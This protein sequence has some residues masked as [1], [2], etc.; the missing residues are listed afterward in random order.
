MEGKQNLIFFLLVTLFI[1]HGIVSGQFSTLW[2]T[3]FTRNTSNGQGNQ[4]GWNPFTGI[5]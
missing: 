1:V 4:A 3:A 2:S 5:L